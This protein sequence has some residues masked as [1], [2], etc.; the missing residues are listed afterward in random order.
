MTFPLDFAA[1][2]TA[3]IC[4]FAGIMVHWIRQ[5]NRQL[6]QIEELRFTYSLKLLE[7]ERNLHEHIA[8]SEQVWEDVARRMQFLEHTLT[9][10]PGN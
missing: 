9:R 1:L 3:V 10:H 6:R 5:V 8:V 4:A 2:D 7:V